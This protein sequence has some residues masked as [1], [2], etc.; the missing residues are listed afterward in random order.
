E[1]QAPGLTTG[2]CIVTAGELRFGENVPWL[3]SC[4]VVVAPDTAIV[5]LASATGTKVIE[6]AVGPVRPD[7]TG[8]YGNGHHVI[9]PANADA[10]RLG[11]EIARVIGGEKARTVVAEA[12]TR[13]MPT[14][15]GVARNALVPRNFTQEEASGFFMQAYYLLAEFRC[16]G[17]LE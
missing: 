14:T 2:R 7:A 16:A 4:E 15:S 10:A 8:P 6:I 13:M 3:R 1:A 5:H 12:M 9:Y 17:R 11:A